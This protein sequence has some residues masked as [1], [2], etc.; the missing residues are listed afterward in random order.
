M[1]AQNQKSSNRL[2]QTRQLR[3][4]DRPKKPKFKI[5]APKIKIRLKYLSSRHERPGG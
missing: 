1:Y 2:A 3:K 4:E 5:I